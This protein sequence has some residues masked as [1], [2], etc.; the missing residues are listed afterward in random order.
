MGRIR[1]A[2]WVVIWVLKGLLM[3]LSPPRRV[4]LLATLI[5]WFFG[6][7]TL[8]LG[9]NDLTV[10]LRRWAFPILLIVLMMELKEKVLARDEIEVARQVQMALLPREHPEP[11]GWSLWS[12]MRVTSRS[13]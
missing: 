1:R 4:V 11:A 8:N 7:L 6:T 5:M 3:K 13:R 10:D 12:Y 2:V 9:E